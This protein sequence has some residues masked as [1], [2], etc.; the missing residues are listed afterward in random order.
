MK[1]ARK[2]VGNAAILVLSRGLGDF[3][4]AL[5]IILIARYLSPEL[6]GQYSVAIT[7]VALLT[8]LLSLGMDEI[9]RREIAKNEKK[10]ASIVKD[11]IVIKS[12]LLL[13]VALAVIAGSL[14]YGKKISGML[15]AAVIIRSLILPFIALSSTLRSVLEAKIKNLGHSL[16]QVST[17]VS[18]LFLAVLIIYLE[19]NYLF[20]IAASTVPFIME[21]LLLLFY[22]RNIQSIRS[23]LKNKMKVFLEIVSDVAC[24]RIFT[25]SRKKLIREAIPISIISLSLTL[26][27]YTD[28]IMLSI[29]K[30]SENVG[31]YAAAININSIAAILI[32][33]VNIA[34]FPLLVGFYKKNSKKVREIVNLAI[35]YA[36]IALI[37]ATMIGATSSLNSQLI[38]LIYGPDYSATS[39]IFKIF[40]LGF[41]FLVVKGILMSAMIATGNQRKVV[42]IIVMASLL[43][44]ILNFFLIQKMGYVGAALA[45]LIALM[46]SA[47]LIY[48]KAKEAINV[49]I[50]SLT[51]LRIMVSGIVGV[52]VM[53]VVKTNFLIDLAAGGLAYLAML[54]MLKT[55][56]NKEFKNLKE[57]LPKKTSSGKLR[58]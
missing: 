26:D 23:D 36:V 55:F 12:F 51:A 46:V 28:I 50:D 44:V 33:G 15:A 38:Q 8:I 43:N 27:S 37:P 54:I 9:T 32:T 10:E 41:F 45:T 57:L 19:V 21:A 1:L 34:I 31:H 4:T 39:E 29:L 2:I 58:F 53:N 13:V 20:M 11:A 49:R 3:I 42:K 18:F 40:A 56:S 48:F 7:F 14:Y 30:T 16:I 25:P 22:Q 47:T 24:L 5:S 6:Y 35:K 52:S 17:K